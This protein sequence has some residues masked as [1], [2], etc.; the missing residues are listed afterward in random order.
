M[1]EA[2][3]SL[4]SC[5]QGHHIYKEVW[6]PHIGEELDCRREPSNIKDRYAVAVVNA[7]TLLPHIVGHLLKKISLLCSPFLR[8][9][10]SIKCQIT[11]HKCHSADLPQGGLEVPCLL[12]F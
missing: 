4:S 2:T 9:G 8:R 6:S 12:I 11:G 1:A 3:T 5:V 10:G 7:G